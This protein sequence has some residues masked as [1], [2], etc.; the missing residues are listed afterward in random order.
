MTPFDPFNTDPFFLDVQKNFEEVAHRIG[1]DK[2]I[3][4]R[5]RLPERTFM[6]TVPFRRDNGQVETVMGFRIQHNDSLG[7]YKGGMRYNPHVNLGEVAA[8][9]M[10]MTWKCAVVGLPLGGAKG[11]GCVDP[12]VLNPA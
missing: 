8:L 11:G 2:N 4:R 7:P 6:V 10:T 3:I 1:C 5:L 9:A 12:T